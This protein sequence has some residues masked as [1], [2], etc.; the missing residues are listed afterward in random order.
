MNR[1]RMLT[2]AVCSERRA[3]RREFR[4]GSAASFCAPQPKGVDSKIK[5]LKLRP[6]VNWKGALKQK[7]LKQTGVKQG[8]PV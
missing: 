3:S 5:A 6:Y 4:I 2:D 1:K 8:F 7:G